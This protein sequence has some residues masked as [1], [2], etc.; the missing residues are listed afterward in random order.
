MVRTW[1][2]A[3]LSDLEHGNQEWGDGLDVLE[4]PHRGFATS[5]IATDSL[6]LGGIR[7]I[8]ACAARFSLIYIFHLPIFPIG[9]TGTAKASLVGRSPQQ[10]RGG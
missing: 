8:T 5:P 1:N 2:S 9:E 6:L 4:N 3:P 10:E 7:L